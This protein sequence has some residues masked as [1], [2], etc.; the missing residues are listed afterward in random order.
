MRSSCGLEE[1]GLDL[2]GAMG[3]KEHGAGFSGLL[4]RPWGKVDREASAMIFHA[5]D[6]EE[7]ASRAGQVLAGGFTEQDPRQIWMWEGW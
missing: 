3:A 4:V 5:N 1:V 2:N 7:A 6:G